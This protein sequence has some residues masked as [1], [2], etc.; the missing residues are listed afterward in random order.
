M[1]LAIT[2]QVSPAIAN[3]ELTHLERQLIDLQ[4]A[5]AQ[6]RQYEQALRSLGVQVL[7]LPAEPDLPDSVFVEDAALVLDELALLTRP[8]ADSRKPEVESIARA[9]EPYRRLV[10]IRAPG[11]LDGGDIL[12]L[13]RTIF[14]GLGTRSNR[15]AIGQMQA[16]LEPFNY[17]V[18]GVKVTGCLHL[19][20]AVTQAAEATLLINP[21]WV[22][23]GE[24]AGYQLIEVHPTEEYAANALL[25]G[26]TLLYQPCFP[27]TRQRLE[28][29]GLR[30]ELVEASELGKAEGALTCCSLIF[31]A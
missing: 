13:G 18:T 23:K 12:Q 28:A 5:R 19:K 25:I 2:R 21:A 22:D 15:S 1:L 7:S 27:K 24:F 31:T 6:H 30:L 29:A 10:Y 9:L 3:C 17:R 14:V 16:A 20:S 26:G 8:G 11:R 4:V